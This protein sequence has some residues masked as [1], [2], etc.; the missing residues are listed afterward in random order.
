MQYTKP[1]A[2]LIDFFERF[3]SIGPKSAQRMALHLLKMPNLEVEK[4]ANLMIEAKEKIHYCSIC[5]NMSQNDPCE[6]CQNLNRDN[7]TICVVSE[8]KDLLAIEKTNEYNG[9]YHVLQ[10]VISP[11]EGIGANDIRIRELLNRISGNDVEEIIL[12]LNPTV[13]GEATSLYICKLLKPFDIKISRIAM[14]LPI[15]SDLEYADEIT[16]SKALE[17]RVCI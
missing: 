4:F 11:L 17:C 2:N 8:T 12:A 16:L 5:Y 1:L 14:G 15:G 13:E 7:K 10:G 3:P 9:V 6:I